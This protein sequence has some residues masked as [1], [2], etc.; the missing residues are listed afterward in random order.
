[1]LLQEKVLNL[2]R[3]I[4]GEFYRCREDLV[5]EG[6]QFSSTLLLEIIGFLNRVCTILFG[7][8]GQGKTT[9]A[10][11]IGS[12]MAGLPYPVVV[13]S[14]VRGA[15]E[16]TEEKLIAIVDLGKLQQGE[17][18]VIW[19]P[20]VRSP[21]HIVDEI[22]RIPEIKQSMLLEGIRTGRWLYLG[23]ILEMGR[24]PLFATANFED[25]TGGSFQLI[26]ALM[27]RFV[28]GLDASYPGVKESLGIALDPDLEAKLAQA[29]LFDY[30]EEASALLTAKGYDRKALTEFS[31]SFKSHLEDHGWT[32]LYKA[33]LEQ[34]EREIQRMP[35]SERAVRFMGFLT[36]TLN[37]CCRSGQKRSAR[38][39]EEGAGGRECPKDCRFY[40]APCSLVIGGGSRRQERDIVQTA[41][42]LAWLLGA[43]EVGVEHIR[44][45]TPFCLWHRRGF[46]QTL[47]KKAATAQRR[48]GYPLKLEA[49]F[50]FAE[51]LHREFVEMHDF[52]E[53]L[54]ENEEDLKRQAQLDGAQG[55]TIG[56]QRHVRLSELHPYAQDVLGVAAFEP[57]TE[58]ASTGA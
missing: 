50:T 2:Y 56:R 41:R 32:P 58:S 28:L 12:I 24:T 52:I 15:P 5:V 14:E 53:Y 8:Y 13:L 47:V 27:D 54:H 45:C 29:G 18:V 31:E 25:L 23:Q 36:S 11:L 55:I 35:L 30:V 9:S 49:A 42:A 1:M 57:V 20:F 38:F 4:R 34:A 40:R 39:G 19:S 37:F 44:I 33:E 26:P 10:E 22:T 6:R 48:H 46:S 17:V 43:G 3:L 7:D 21:V 16:I 51:E